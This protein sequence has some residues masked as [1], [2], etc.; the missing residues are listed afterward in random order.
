L[1]HPVQAKFTASSSL[2]ISII[3]ITQQLS[4]KTAPYLYGDSVC[5]LS[6]QEKVGISKEIVN[7]LLTATSID[8]YEH[9]ILITKDSKTMFTSLF[10]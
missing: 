6:E 5:F 2:N 9:P 8:L 7:N 1:P 3:S 10:S 4:L